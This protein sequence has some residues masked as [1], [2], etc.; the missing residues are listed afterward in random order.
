M[1]GFR[2]LLFL[3]LCI[4]ASSED[5]SSEENRNCSCSA[6]GLW[7]GHRKLHSSIS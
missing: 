1:F 4:L 5:V 6:K 3:S 2:A 7:V